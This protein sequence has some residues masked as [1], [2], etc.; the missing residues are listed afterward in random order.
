MEERLVDTVILE[1]GITYYIEEEIKMN[2]NTYYFLVNIENPKDSCFRKQEIEN[3]K[4]FLVTLDNMEE[5]SKV[6]ALLTKKYKK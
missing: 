2:N 6:L 1:D 5:L 3:G 4:E